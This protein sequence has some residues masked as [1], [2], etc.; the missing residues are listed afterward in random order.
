MKQNHRQCCLVS[1][2]L[3]ISYKDDWQNFPLKSCDQ[4]AKGFT[5]SCKSIPHF[6]YSGPKPKT[7]NGC[8]TFVTCD[9]NLAIIISSFYPILIMPCGACVIWLS[10][11]SK[12]GRSIIWLEDRSN[13]SAKT[14]VSIQP[15]TQ[16]DWMKNSNVKENIKS[17]TN[18]K[19]ET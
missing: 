13:H 19:T 6:L 17:F 5:C 16:I 15:I 10:N 11:K 2:H 7:C 9:R 4:A 3:S 8:S 18:S 14:S 12:R 1:I